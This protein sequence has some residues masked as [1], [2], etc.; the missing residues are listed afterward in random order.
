MCFKSQER[1]IE[2]LCDSN[3][4]E[5]H[6]VC[7]VSKYNL[8]HEEILLK[9]IIRVCDVKKDSFISTINLSH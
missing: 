1:F 2:I 9:I 6:S 8:N 3:E 5:I 4:L 7:K